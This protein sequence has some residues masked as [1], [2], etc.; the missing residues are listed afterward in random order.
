MK[1]TPL[2]SQ[3]NNHRI[4]IIDD[5]PSIHEDFRKILGPADAKLAEE[6]DA[7][8]ASL[9]GDHAGS[10]SAQNFRIDSAFQGQEGLEKVRAACAE[11]APYAVAFVDVRMPPG[12]DGIETISRIWKE[13]P[14]LQI[15]ICTAYSD[16]SWDEIAKSVGNT[17]KMLV[18]KKPFD[19]VEVLQMAHALSKK[20]QLTQMGR[21]QMEELDALVN[22]RTAEL[23]A[24]NARLTGEVAERA[25]AEEALRRSEERFSKAF[26]SSPV[27]MAIQRP[28]G[29]ACLDANISFLELV[30][31]SREAVLAGSTTFWAD[32]STPTVLRQELAARHA[33][34]N[35][36]ATIR[37]TSDETREVLVAAENLELGNASYHLLILQDI[38]DRVR[39]ENEL[40]QAQKME[41]VGRLAAGVA[42]DFNNI[43]TVILGN[44]S[45]QLRNPRLDKKL[46]CSLTQVQRAAERATALTRQLLAYSRKQIIQRRPLAL[47]E[48]VEQTVAMLRR[49][50]GE[51]IALD[52]QLAPD[53]PPIFADPSNVEQVIMNLALNARD[54]MPDG[55]KLTLAT[56]RVEI[57]KA[58]RAR[59]PEAQLGPF[60]C[61]A[62]KDTGYGMDA[63]TVGRI[64]E[65]F[66]TTKDPG[67]GTGMGLATVYGVLK[68]HGGWIEVDT[69]PGRGT[70]I[71][72]FFPLSKEGFVA[73]SAKSE[74]LP[75]ESTPINDITI[76][77]VED[78]EM[79][80]EFV[81]EALGTLGYHVLSAANG[82]DALNVWAEHRDEIALLLTDVVMP[83]SISG[84]QLAHTL[85]Q[86]K[87]NLKVIFTSGYS[88]E[89]FESEFEREKEHVFLA[90]P[91]LPDRLAQTVAMHLQSQGAPEFARANS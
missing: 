88:S 65:P 57:D 85:I 77:V 42:H 75:T 29:K 83:E 24:A 76:L 80:R 78:E 6:L 66:F 81:S 61:L 37:T 55:G 13:F 12:W 31:A 20:W 45:T 82:R 35:L 86:D 68:Q 70:S 1:L 79:L 67:Q 17:D 52:M 49:L 53:L 28:E 73:A 16:Y 91:Y 71:R 84:R 33:V 51:H 21:K 5:N 89:L 11:G 30:G 54:A 27:P 15:V 50:I 22:Q 90:K 36:A 34:R 56:T 3:P 9:F 4:L 38:T 10:S 18:L 59:N 43:L 2:T 87:P 63:A 25:A 69:A 41:A 44:T 26:H 46:T 62:V 60:I 23:R 14:D 74:S 8:E 48:V 64:F 72:T 7:T 39:L 32:E 19:N 47:N 40:R 58:S